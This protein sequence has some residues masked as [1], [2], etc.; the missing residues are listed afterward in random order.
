LLT[1]PINSLNATQKQQLATMGVNLQPYAGFPATQT[2]RQAL[3]PYPQYTGLISP[4]GAPVGK[5]W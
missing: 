2:V 5:N 1:T 4:V 3:L